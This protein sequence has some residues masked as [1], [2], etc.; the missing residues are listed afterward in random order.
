MTSPI[1]ENSS[2]KAQ[3]CKSLRYRTNPAH[4]GATIGRVANRLKDARIDNLNG[5][6]VLLEA[7][8]GPNTLHGG[9]EGWGLK[10]W[11]GPELARDV[12]H[13][14]ENF[15]G[16]VEAWVRYS[17]YEEV[18]GGG[19]K[20]VVL[21]MEYEAQLVDGAEETVLN[22]TNH[23]FA[24]KSP[25]P[26]NPHLP[27]DSTGIPHSTDISPYPGITPNQ[28]FTLGLTEPDIDDCFILNKDPSSILLDTR[29]LPLTTFLTTEPAFQFYT[30]KYVNVV[31]RADGSPRRV[32][33]AGFCVEPSR[34]VNAANVEAWRGMTVVK[35][36]EVFG[37]KI[38]YRAWKD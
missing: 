23:T 31:P 12:H 30:G 15:P 27:P 28:T 18:E 4:F 2:P 32:L 24:H 25:P 3:S 29:P 38:V 34:Y 10:G 26:T 5:G 19:E 22:S 1:S 37:C 9:K 35:K 11:R 33:R 20:A 36:G 6:V 16:E 14:D 7:N 8:N 17:P 13:G 21:E